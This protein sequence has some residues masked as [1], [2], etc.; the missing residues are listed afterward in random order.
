[1]TE[2][3]NIINVFRKLVLPHALH[4]PSLDRAQPGTR[5]PGTER[6]GRRN[7]RSSEVVNQ[8]VG[9]IGS[10]RDGLPQAC[11][12]VTPFLGVANPPPFH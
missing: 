4:A 10:I 5:F 7:Q 3:A 2:S 12:S 8:R 11:S 9:L 1:M 6:E